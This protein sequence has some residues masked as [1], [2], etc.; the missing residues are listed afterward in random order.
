MNLDALWSR[1]PTTITANLWSL[2]K[3]ITTC[4][5]AGIEPNI[6]C[7]GP[8]PFEDKFGYFVAFSMLVHSRQPGR[9][10]DLYTQFAIIR[11]QHSA[12][13]NL[14]MAPTEIYNAP[15]MLN[16]G[17]QKNGKLASCTTNSQWFLRWSLGCETWM[18]Y[19]VKQ[20]QAISTQVLKRLINIFKDDIQKSNYW[21][22]ECW[23]AALGFTYSIIYFFAS[24][25]G[26]ETL[27]VH[28]N[29]LK[30]D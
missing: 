23:S 4:E 20:N 19:I 2:A 26:S 12:F 11:K 10:S 15:I 16:S 5:V 6:P 27:K 28:Y 29:M 24:L 8:M 1:E 3:L 22:L 7:M 13:N 25:R 14:F 30:H 9:H 17:A 18:G 21:S